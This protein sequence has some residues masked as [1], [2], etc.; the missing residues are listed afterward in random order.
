MSDD[1]LPMQVA[2]AQ[3]RH[4]PPAPVVV[5]VGGQRVWLRPEDAEQVRQAVERLLS[6]YAGDTIELAEESE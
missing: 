5:T 3:L 1:Y 6:D 2:L 4:D